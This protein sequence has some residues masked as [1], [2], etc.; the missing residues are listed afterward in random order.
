MLI[1]V[2]RFMT[3]DDEINRERQTAYKLKP[4]I[5]FPGNP[6]DN[7][8]NLIIN[9]SQIYFDL[10]NISSNSSWLIKLTITV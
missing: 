8:N 1:Y 7:A 9:I 5:N 10:S 2:D 6:L 3:L 4:I